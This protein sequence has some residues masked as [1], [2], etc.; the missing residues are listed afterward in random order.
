MDKTF[1]MHK[2][3]VAVLPSNA[4]EVRMGLGWECKRDL[5]L[6]ASIIAVT[7]QNRVEYVC[8][9][10]DLKKPGVTHLGDNLTG[11]GDGDDEVIVVNLNQIPQ[12]VV[13]LYLT[14]HCF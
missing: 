2:G 1:E 7:A 11:E 8:Y 4:T 6:D 13:S 5:D 14:V 9:Y 3:D 12:H 10:R